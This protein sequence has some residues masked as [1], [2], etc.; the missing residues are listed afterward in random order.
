[1]GEGIAMEYRIG[2]GESF[3]ARETCIITCISQ[4]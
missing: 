3:K 2:M 4:K 1:M